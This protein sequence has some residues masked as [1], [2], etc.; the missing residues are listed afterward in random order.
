MDNEEMERLKAEKLEKAREE[1]RKIRMA[2]S[3]AP[4]P[5]PDFPARP[6]EAELV[7]STALCYGFASRTA[8]ANNVDS[9]GALLS[10]NYHY[11]ARQYKD[12][13]G[14]TRYIRFGQS[15]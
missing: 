8:S 7:E 2:K 12:Y 14:Y 15:Y 10:N 13:E 4:P 3:P 6:G 11:Y 1:L 9:T 5:V